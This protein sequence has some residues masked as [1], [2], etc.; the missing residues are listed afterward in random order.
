MARKAKRVLVVSDFHCGHEVGLTPPKWNPASGI[1]DKTAYRSYMWQQ[2]FKT[3]R[4]LQPIDIL[5]ANGDLID[6][7]GERSGSEELIVLDRILQAQMAVATL[8]VC[9]ADKIFVTRG[10]DYHVGHEESWED[11]VA[12]DLKAE[13]VGD[14][15]N[16][17]INGLMVNA[18]HHIGGSQT[19]LGRTTPL[20]REAVWNALW[21]VRQGFPQADVMI[22]SHVH[23]H[24][25]TGGPGW[26]AMTT[27]GLQ[28]YGTRFGERRMSGLIDFGLIYFDITS[29]DDFEWH[30][31][32]WPFPIPEPVRA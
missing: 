11:L 9:D 1:D 30:S 14:I 29:R 10:T 31:I 24:A 20:A 21:S 19:P 3:V 25:F 23:Y 12:S 2:F 17:D 27:P 13:R 32:C 22:R 7:R 4:S 5:I 8:R 18:R 16:I 26:L 15:L 28:G 6:G